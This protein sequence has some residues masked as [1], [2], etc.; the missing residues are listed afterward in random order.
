MTFIQLTVEESDVQVILEA[1]GK[2]SQR[3]SLLNQPQQVK[4]I[5]QLQRDIKNQAYDQTMFS[6]G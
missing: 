5:S 6:N 4:V 1:L 2:Q 3:A